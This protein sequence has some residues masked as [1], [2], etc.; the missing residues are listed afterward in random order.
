M[1]RATIVSLLTALVVL[2]SVP[3]QAHQSYPFWYLSAWTANPV[4]WFADHDFDLGK[5]AEPGKNEILYGMG[6]WNAAPGSR[7]YYNNGSRYDIVFNVPG[8]Y[9][10][11]G[12]F[13]QPLSGED[14]WARIYAWWY[15]SPSDPAQYFHSFD[16]VF[17]SALKW[18]MDHTKA[19]TIAQGDLYSVA[20]HEFGHGMGHWTHW[21][22]G[23]AA[24]AKICVPGPTIHTMCSTHYPGTTSQRSLATHDVHTF[25]DAYP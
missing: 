7:I 20:S 19:P 11:N 8:T 17:N 22:Q 1:R 12:I 6:V 15:T 23:P 10:M 25:T 5:V 4:T 9:N 2:L 18:N 16:V 24:D 3:A 21:D 13:W 14:V